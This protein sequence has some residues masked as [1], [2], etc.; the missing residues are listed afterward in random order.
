MATNHEVKGEKLG[1][2]DVWRGGQELVSGSHVAGRRAW[3]RTDGNQ[4]GHLDSPRFPANEASR[5]LSLGLNRNDALQ[6][7]GPLKSLQII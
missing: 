5:G 1:G 3:S 2:S 4:W 6:P 7:T